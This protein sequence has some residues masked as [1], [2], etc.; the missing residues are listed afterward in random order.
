MK[1]ITAFL[2]S[3]LMMLNSVCIVFA[4]DTESVR[5]DFPKDTEIALGLFGALGGIEYDV[6]E[7]GALSR[8]EFVNIMMTLLKETAYDGESYYYDVPAVSKYY[9]EINLA[10]ALGYVNGTDTNIFSP[11]EKISPS[12]VAKILVTV[13]GYKPLAQM[14]GGDLSAYL[15]LA[16]KLDITDGIILSSDT[17]SS[18]DA[19]TMIYRAFVAERYVV[20]GVTSGGFSYKNG[21]TILYDVLD[22]RYTTG[23]VYANEITALT[24]YSRT[25]KNEIMVGSKCIKNASKDAQTR[26]GMNVLCFYSEETNGVWEY[27]WSCPL[28]NNSVV[29]NAEDMATTAADIG[30]NTIKYYLKDSLRSVSYSRTADI[31]LNGVNRGIDL[32]FEHIDFEVGYIELVDN[33]CDGTYDVVKVYELEYICA[34]AP[35][36]ADSKVLTDAYDVTR[37]LV[38]DEN[39]TDIFVAVYDEDGETDITAIGERCIV[40]YAESAVVDGAK[41]V[42]MHISGK[43]VTGTLE[44]KSDDF[45]KINGEKYKV[46]KSALVTIPSAGAYGLFRLDYEGAVVAYDAT[47]TDDLFWGFVYSVGGKTN[48]FGDTLALRIFTEGGSFVNYEC[49]ENFR[50]NSAKCK[51]RSA[52]ETKLW[53]TPFMEGNIGQVVK[54]SVDTEGKINALYTASSDYENAPKAG[55]Y[56]SRMFTR[57]GLNGMGYKLYDYLVDSST[58]IMTVGPF[59]EVTKTFDEKY[60]YVCDYWS[61][62]QSGTYM[63]QPYNINDEIVAP[64]VLF[65]CKPGSVGSATQPYVVKDVFS[66]LNDEG[67]TVTKL[68]L[69]RTNV[70]YEFVAKDDETDLFYGLERGDFVKIL[71]DWYGEVAAA[72]TVFIKQSELKQGFYGSRF[73]YALKIVVGRILRIK[74]TNAVITFTD[75]DPVGGVSQGDTDI[76]AI[77]GYITLFNLETGESRKIEVSEL[78]NYADR[79][80]VIVN[81]S[82]S[83]KEAY[84][85]V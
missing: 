7:H 40:A 30:N 80:I 9:S 5:Q 59:N 38:I 50:L 24:G 41:C 44:S 83:L 15:R 18:E 42:T 55:E 58:K 47:E 51:T 65:T 81:V 75:P 52:L 56:K 11:D 48:A 78:M 64:F 34:S 17:V 36:Y 85:F 23:I 20:D 84:I 25:A 68:Q 49:S 74:G 16:A 63:S 43:T 28:D 69:L 77:G 39:G 3:L 70:E 73:D 6:A 71:P 22:I 53:E 35:M 10:T 2:V 26:L 79:D 62:D 4:K 60:F 29:I 46:R 57:R 67:E 37:R 54:Y 13:L 14:N 31:F 33:D 12:Q 66:E 45:L 61:P 82:G 1:K 21:N 76:L 27:L 19:L 72:P 8:G 32:G